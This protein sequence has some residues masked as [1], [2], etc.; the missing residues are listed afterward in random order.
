MTTRVCH[1]CGSE[2]RR[3]EGVYF[4]EMPVEYVID[5]V[6]VTGQWWIQCDNCGEQLLPREMV[7]VL[8]EVRAYVERKTAE[9]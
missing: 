4:A 9:A 8:E 5:L 6:A 1:N 3:A 7:S 2:M